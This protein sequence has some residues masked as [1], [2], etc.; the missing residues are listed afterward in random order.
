MNPARQVS[1]ANLL[2]ANN[3]ALTAHNKNTLIGRNKRNQLPSE[4]KSLLKTN[5]FHTFLG[6]VKYK[7]I[8][9][10]RSRTAMRSFC[11]TIPSRPVTLRKCKPTTLLFES[12]LTK[13]A[14]SRRLRNCTFPAL[15]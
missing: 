8:L 12:L 9:W 15:W 1:E 5:R 14:I 2:N 11:V 13:P 10:W 4:N 7:P 3:Q 6:F